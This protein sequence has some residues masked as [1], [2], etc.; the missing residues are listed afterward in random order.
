MFGSQALP[1]FTIDPLVFNLCQYGAKLRGWL[2][3]ASLKLEDVDNL[4]KRL[5]TL[6]DAHDIS[7][8][9]E[10]GCILLKFHRDGGELPSTL[11]FSHEVAH[12][13]KQGFENLW[14]NILLYCLNNHCLQLLPA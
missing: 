12:V 4:L 8:L 5:F 13:G 11:K 7:S 2:V 1:I 6:R 9:E 14:L 3:P 10:H